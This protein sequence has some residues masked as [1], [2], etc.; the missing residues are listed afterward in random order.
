MF[1]RKKLFCVS[2]LLTGFS[3]VQDSVYPMRIAQMMVPCGMVKQL[4]GDI[5]LAE[6]QVPNLDHE[7]A[8][9]D[10]PVVREEAIVISREDKK[11]KENLEHLIAEGMQ[12]CRLPDELRAQRFYASQL[13]L[14]LDRMEVL[15][16]KLRFNANE[17][18]QERIV[19]SLQFLAA[20]SRNI[21]SIQ[22]I[23]DVL[24]S[25]TSSSCYKVRDACFNVWEILVDVN[26]RSVHA[27]FCLCAAEKS[28]KNFLRSYDLV[29]ME[30]NSMQGFCC[31][32]S[33]VK[34]I[35]LLVQ[36]GKAVG[37]AQQMVEDLSRSHDLM[38]SD[39][40]FSI[41]GS[42]IERLNRL[43]A[44]ERKTAY[45]FYLKVLETLSRES[46]AQWVKDKASHMADDLR[47]LGQKLWN[48]AAK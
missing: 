27:D 20:E 10:D 44:E 37:L 14:V 2:L 7:E 31:D 42:L 21:E 8:L 25:L 43:P 38:L 48:A 18:V 45:Y 5:V 28:I 35:C 16:S 30:E 3:C 11:N 6:G 36:N 47:A 12:W 41:L 40:C 26:L 1:F 19:A 32:E 24:T 34:L 13:F 9:L 33:L 23:V 4:R 39:Y 22:L 15:V 46:V 17:Q 29:T